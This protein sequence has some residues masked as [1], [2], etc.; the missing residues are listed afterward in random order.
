SMKKVEAHSRITIAGNPPDNDITVIAGGGERDDPAE[1]PSHSQPAP[2]AVLSSSR[3]VLILRKLRFVPDSPL[4]G[5]GFEISVPR[6]IGSDFEGF[7]RIGADRQLGGG[8][9]PAVVGPAN[10]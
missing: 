10:R 1:P 4:E 7:G 6:Q 2:A 3:E 8:I 5:N 9:I